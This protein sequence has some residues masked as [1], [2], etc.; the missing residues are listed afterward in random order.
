MNEGPNPARP[1]HACVHA[2]HACTPVNFTHPR[3]HTGDDV[4]EVFA[5][6]KAADVAEEAPKVRPYGL[7]VIGF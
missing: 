5:A 7:R 1:S 3:A 6:E 4:E 2:L